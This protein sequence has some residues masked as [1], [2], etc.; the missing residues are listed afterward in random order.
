[1][2]SLAGFLMLHL[3]LILPIN[4]VVF[5][6]DGVLIG[7]G[8]LRYLAGGHAG[9]RGSVRAPRGGH[10]PRR[11]RHR[12]ALGHPGCLHGGLLARVGLRFADR[13]WVRLGGH[14]A[15]PAIQVGLGKPSRPI[16]RQRS[17]G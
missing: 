1:M 8:D 15:E 6:L 10:A 2:V 9:R 5:A 16:L 13:P 11:R 17:V 12:L 7:A 4:G 14:Q 3:A